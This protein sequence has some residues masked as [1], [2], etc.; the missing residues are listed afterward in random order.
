MNTKLLASI[1]VFAL[2]TGVI[3][4]SMMQSAYAAD[5]GMDDKSDKKVADAKKLADKKAADAKKMADK[6]VVDAKKDAAADKAAAGTVTVDIAKGTATNTECG[7]KCFVPNN[8]QVKVGG[9][10]IWKNVDTAAHTATDSNGAF[11]SSM[12]MAKGS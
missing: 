3:S 10:V 5:Y 6:K 11:D 2:L 4:T 7:Y 1:A 8:V 12:V 9:T